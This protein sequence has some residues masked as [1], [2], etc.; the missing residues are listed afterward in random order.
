MS[1]KVID[2]N[3]LAYQVSEQIINLIRRGEFRPGE[4]L[5]PERELAE[6][7][8]VSRG[9]VREAL[10]ALQAA[11][12]VVTKTGAGTFVN[13]QPLSRK[14]E[15]KALAS[16]LS[17]ESPIEILE[18]REALES[19]AVYMAAENRTEEDIL[20]M[21][22][23]LERQRKL[24][25]KGSDP[26]PA[27]VEFHM[28]IARASYNS[29]LVRMMEAIFSLMEQTFWET[30]MKNLARQVYMQESQTKKYIREHENILEA[31]KEQNP[32]LAKQSMCEHIS[33]VIDNIYKLTQQS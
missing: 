23:A 32:E 26:K 19:K 4:R 16:A 33:G 12:V 14:L 11:G 27:D 15:F 20:R 6:K 24:I 8:G 30:L 28:A 5:P 7:M 21:S 29:V 2:K 1:F 22:E 25:E 18:V 3:R 13:D 10:S 31:I 17:D 9:S